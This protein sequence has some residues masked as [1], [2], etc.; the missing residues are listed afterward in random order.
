MTRNEILYVFSLNLQIIVHIVIP[1]EIK[2]SKNFIYK[3][4]KEYVST[5]ILLMFTTQKQ[6]LWTYWRC[7][8]YTILL[9]QQ[10]RVSSVASP[11]I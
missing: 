5:K 8:P 6:R 10:Y 11:T 2:Q 4:V 7:I 9:K 1:I 3:T